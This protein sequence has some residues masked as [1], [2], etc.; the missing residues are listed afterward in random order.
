MTVAIDL[1]LACRSSR[2]P[3]AEQFQRWA[4]TALKGQRDD[5]ELT[6]RIVDDAESQC[7]NLTY[8][9]KDQPT[10]V[11]SFPFEAPAGIEMD[12]LGDLVIC[13]AVVAREA[14]E[15][16]KSL[17]HHWAHM[18]IHGIL[19]L[20]GYDHLSDHQAEEMESLETRLLNQL[21]IAN[22]YFDNL[23]I[24]NLDVSTAKIGSPNEAH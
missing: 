15:Q 22:P 4:E 10:N 7:L 1:Q 2:L 11:L 13:A 8:R 5:A 6:I 12:L 23:D 16:Q 3:S 9:G 20:L 18:V 21:G 19:H 24:D 17:E 14:G